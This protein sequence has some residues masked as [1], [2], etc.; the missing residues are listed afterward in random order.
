MEII[1]DV[2]LPL[3]LAFIMF[4]LGLTLTF[5]DFKQVFVQPKNVIVGMLSQII[6]LPAVAFLL[7]VI[8][9][10]NLSPELAIGVMLIAAAPGGVTS[11]I[12]TALGRGDVALSISMTAITS[13]LVLITIPII[14]G[15]SYSFFMGADQAQEISIS[16]IAFS[17][18]AIVTIPVL[19][20]LLIR[21]LF[22]A[23]A[24]KVE[25]FTGKLSTALFV[26]VL[27]GAIAK[28]RHNIIPYFID[29]GFIT[30]LLNI[31][32]M[33]LAFYI[34]KIFGSG[35]KQQIAISIECGLQNGTLAIAI[36]GLLFGG[37]VYIIPAA[38]YSLIMFVTS[39]IFVYL[40]R[41]KL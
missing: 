9:G 18:F 39:L 21:R 32:M 6:L 12:L 1:T 24:L 29:A 27:I 35:M 22:E 20:G 11:N 25:S 5:S 30:L 41:K 4:S 8:W 40:V 15:L 31:S 26:I 17:I 23:F 7:I 38:I 2:F 13:L 28:E 34:A 14:I 33:L 3:A 16:K 37:G 10:N 19:C 36:A